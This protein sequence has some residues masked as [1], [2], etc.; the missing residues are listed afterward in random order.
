MNR[1]RTLAHL[2]IS[3]LFVA[4]ISV[5]WTCGPEDE[6]GS[7]LDGGTDSGAPDSD[8]PDDGSPDDGAPD[9]GAPDGDAPGDCDGLV[10]SC[11]SEGTLQCSED[12]TFIEICSEDEEGCLVWSSH[13][14][15]DSTES[16]QEEGE[17]PA[18]LDS[19]NSCDS[20]GER[21]CRDN[22]IERCEQD[23]EG[24]L[25]WS[26]ERD[27]DSS[28]SVC[29]DTGDRV[30][31][32][33]TRVCSVLDELVCI[34]N[35]IMRCTFGHDSCL[36][37]VVHDDCLA[38]GEGCDDSGEEPVCVCGDECG[39]EGLR[40]CNGDE[41]EICALGDEGCLEWVTDRD[42][43]SSGGVCDSSGVEPTCVCRGDC[44]I[45]GDQRCSDSEIQE[46]RRGAD[47]CLT[48]ATIEDC[49]ESDAA[50]VLDPVGAPLCDDCT[51]GRSRCSPDLC[52][53]ETCRREADGTLTWEMTDFCCDRPDWLCVASPG[54]A[55]CDD[56]GSCGTWCEG[57]L[58]SASC[59]DEDTIEH[60]NNEPAGGIC[61]IRW[62]EEDCP[63]GMRCEDDGTWASCV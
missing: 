33:C 32:F 23:D 34:S 57:G 17:L 54:R 10:A 39:A 48:W 27:C 53:V 31:C 52:E 49:G 7:L 36:D 26:T 2:K 18:C 8:A 25:R 22:T 43:G 19:C 9:D 29:G 61:D 24:C 60:C 41:N 16:C 63:P 40:R 50:C 38:R 55:L 28:D 44:G 46:C 42:C 3:T 20:E 59:L 14:E 13:E 30:I 45:P 6:P 21:R 11:D 62:Y 4:F 12:A 47:D 56:T 37:W 15:C 58:V 5:G 51:P 1:R 35:M